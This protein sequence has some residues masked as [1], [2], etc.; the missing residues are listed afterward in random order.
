MHA[1]MCSKAC[2]PY[3][4][5][6][7]YRAWN[8]RWSGLKMKN[9]LEKCYAVEP[10]S[11]VP[12]TIVFPHVPFTI[13][14]PEWSSISI[15]L[16]IPTSIVPQTIVLSHWS[17]VNHGPDAAFPTWIVWRKKLRQSI[18]YLHY[19][20]TINLATQSRFAR[21]PQLHVRVISVI[22]ELRCKWFCAFSCDF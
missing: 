9:N 16:F 7:K 15:T 22:S 3:K 8:C 2:L 21:G 13:F 12:A 5:M 1:E 6:T 10:R 14:G 17:F 4:N 20:C 18:Y 11:I 19:L